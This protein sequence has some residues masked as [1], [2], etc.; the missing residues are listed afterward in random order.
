MQYLDSNSGV[1]KWSSEETIVPYYDRVQKKY[2]RYFPDFV[3]QTK[4]GTTMVEIKPSKE[5]SAPTGAMHQDGRK[6]RR[7][8]REQ[9]TY[10]NNICKWEAARDYCADRNW[11]F[12]IVTEKDLGGW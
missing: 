4:A 1:I 9:L 2:R 12:Q 5:T 7:L 3:V 10:A 11:R 6:N 8:I